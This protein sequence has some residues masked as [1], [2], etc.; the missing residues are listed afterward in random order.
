MMLNRRTASF[1]LLL[2]G[3][4]AFGALAGSGCAV[5]RGDRNTVRP[6]AL[7]KKQF[8]GDWYYLKTIIKA[9]YDS[10]GMFPG[11]QAGMVKIRW[12][13]TERFLYAF[14][15]QPSVRNA[16]S[17]VVPVAAWPILGHFTI[18]YRISY[19]TGQPSNVVGEDY[20]DKP[21]YQRPNFRVAWER[22][23]ITDFTG[24]SW[25]YSMFGY[26]VREMPTNVRPEEVQI[27]PEFMDFVNEE[28]VSP[29]IGPLIGKLN[30]GLPVSAFRIRFRHSFK[31]VPDAKDITYT[32][33][34]M[35]DDQF[36]KFGYF[37]TGIINY[38]VDRG[39][40]DWSYQYMANRHNVANADEIKAG[41]KKPK[42]IIYYLSKNFPKDMKKTAY[43]IA[44][45]WNKAFQRALR[46]PGEQIYVVR[47][48]DHGLPKG[49]SRNMGDVRYN[50]LYW[51]RP[52]I[53]FGLLGY[54]PSF[55]DYDT[56]EI[57]QASAYVYGATVL[58]VANR[59]MLLYDMVSGRYTDEDLRNGKDYLDIINNFSGGTANPLVS[60]PKINI[61]KPSYQ[62]FSIQKADAY[63][64]S[65][66]FFQ[67]NKMLRSVNRAAIQS[68]LARLDA[69]PSLKWAMMPDETLRALFPR[70][71]LEQLRKSQD[72][73][74]KAALNSYL[75]PGNLM[76]I[77]SIRGVMKLNNMMSRR[78]MM[79]GSYVDPALSK[80][81]Q[82]HI[83]A[84]TPRSKLYTL[85][86]QMI[87]RGTEGH[88][89]GH[90]LGLRHNF[91]ASADEPNYF[92][93]YA[94]LKKAQ[95]G[96]IPGNDNQ[97]EHAW[98]Y[99]YSSIM[100]YHGDVYGDTVG[101]GTYDHAAIMYAYGDI[102]EAD[103]SLLDASKTAVK[104]YLD[105]VA[106]AAKK[107]ASTKY[108]GILK[109][110]K[111]TRNA[112]KTFEGAK[113]QGS[114]KKSI[115]FIASQ[116]LLKV[117]GTDNNGKS[118]TIL[119]LTADDL[120][121]LQKLHQ[122]FALTGVKP[123]TNTGAYGDGSLFLQPADPPLQRHFYRFCSD[124]LVGQTPYCTRFDSGSNPRQMV[125][126]MIRR[127]DG[128]YPLRNWNRGRRYYRLSSGYFYRMISQFSIIS[129][130]YQNWI[131]RVINERGYQGSQ[132]YF[133][134][135]AAVQ[136][137]L[138]FVNR[139]IQTPDP[140]RH[141]LDKG[142][143]AYVQSNA[144]S[145]D[146]IDVPVG[147]GR[148]F[149]SKLQ[150]DELGLAQYRFE[151]IGTMYDKYVALMAL[152]IRDWGLAANS[153]NFFYV[154][155]ADY[156]SSD[157]VTDMFTS[158]ISGVFDNKRY[159]MT[160]NDKILTPNWHP[161]LQYTS[162]SMAMSMLNNGFFGN[163]F[164]NYMTIGIQGS[165]RSWTAPKAGTVISFSNSANTRTYFAVQTEDGRSISYKLVA[166]GK[167]L[168]KRVKELRALPTSAV[169]QAE[170]KTAESQLVWVETV[171]QMMK[172]YVNIF[173]RNN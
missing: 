12:E 124:E 11:S 101:I 126:N 134:Q 131:Y 76:R 148:Y 87:L 137:G 94:E 18:R 151:R 20:L 65:P 32:K 22:S 153:L 170:L 10:V 169:N 41:S 88:E 67:R 54:G 14:T 56:G 66:S 21:W 28:V 110:I 135:L 1:A 37:R 172:A 29:G 103:S 127:Y 154:N 68:R 40:V 84:K 163:T 52:A 58:R 23:V 158:A 116:V 161:V 26:F 51:V 113:Y 15:T 145:K 147:V 77:S 95:G 27:H 39:L 81:V 160:V 141:I 162:M 111:V 57:V 31:K 105:K 34:G 61:K 42:Q 115:Q 142:T 60:T 171:L 72:E 166:R 125:E 71:S 165:G 74:V 152:A 107:L 90:T 138:S 97:V 5:H 149:Y 17:T 92:P 146:S 156:F 164:T 38:N 99:M 2:L 13:I 155:F 119:Q 69:K 91:E 123:R 128:N 83:K 55:A 64:K 62:G 47:E 24:S 44:Q 117:E 59:F 130:F 46:R 139:V 79:L 7:D 63:V 73:Q 133:D 96:N 6:L 168:A 30:R 100:D 93:Q 114:K 16:D 112:L 129:L 122:V 19:A 43:L 109:D 104:T 144:D 50:F 150:E 98:F 8:Q 49:Q 167:A 53:S 78:N 25:Y 33:H 85:M 132:D 45:D 70:T 9:P 89:I 102:L 108:S 159:S 82:A 35:N 86:Q 4:V 48:N 80:F 121:G 75:N 173:A 36:A 157:D 140:G 3:A 106:A 118:R 143:N 136:R 120:S